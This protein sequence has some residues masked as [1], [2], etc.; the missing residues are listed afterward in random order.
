M[1]VAMPL[2]RR[3]TPLRHTLPL[4]FAAPPLPMILAAAVAAAIRDIIL[5][6]AFSLMLFCHVFAIDY[7][8]FC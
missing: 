1:P 2:R 6:S 8:L 7:A 5:Y 3:L 4:F